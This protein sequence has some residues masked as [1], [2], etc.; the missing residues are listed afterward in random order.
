MTMIS[1]S[2]KLNRFAGTSPNCVRS[3]A[4][5]SLLLSSVCNVQEAA[6][7]HRIWLNDHDG[8]AETSIVPIVQNAN[9]ETVDA[10]AD[11]SA[12]MDLSTIRNFIF[13]L[14]I[15]MG[16]LSSQFM[17]VRNWKNPTSIPE[18]VLTIIATEMGHMITILM[19]LS[20]GLSIDLHVA[21]MKKIQLNERKY[22]VELCKVSVF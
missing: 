8:S 7:N 18:E 15:R 10:S 16:H 20:N 9:N 6:M 5:E 2:G 21:C 12:S 22:P 17:Q 1:P 4:D 19:E 11:F 14:S 3:V 13:S